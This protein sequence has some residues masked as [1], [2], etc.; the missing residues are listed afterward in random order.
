MANFP[1]L[2]LTDAGRQLQAK[3][4]IGAALT[5]SR[6]GLG[7]GGAD[8][9]ESMAALANE[10]LSLSI[11]DFEVV[12]DGTSRMRV[13][14]T[15]EHLESGFFVRE[16][17]VFARD[18]DT[19]EEVLY[20]YTNAGG[21]PDFLP[22][23][24]G[25][26]LVENVFDLYT[27]VGNA[28]NVT[29][30]INDYITIA[31]KQDVD[32]IR[33]LLLPT[34]GLVGQQPR[35][36]SNADGDVEWFDPAEGVDLRMSSVE[37]RRIAI[38]GQRTFGLTTTTTQ[39][40][41]IYVNGARMGRNRWQ[42]LGSTQMRFNTPL[43]DGDEV[44]FVQNEETGEVRDPRV[45]LTGDDLIYPGTENV[46]VVTDYDAF[47]SYEVTAS[48]GSV[49]RNG[50]AIMLTL[51]ADEPDGS[52]DLNIT[53][54]GTG[55]TYSLAVGAPIVRQ[56]ELISPGSGDTGVELTPT[57]ATASF[58]T[59][60]DAFDD[61]ASSDWQVATDEAFADIVWSA[62][63]STSLT[64]AQVPADAL[65]LNTQL[66]ARARH[67]GATLG[68]S[69]WSAV[70]AFTTTDQYIVRPEVVSP[71]NNATG[72]PES[73]IIEAS[74]FVTHPAG[75][76]THYATSWRLR[77]SG[78][79]VVWESL[80]DTANLNAVAIPAGVMQESTAYSVEAQYI[81]NSLPNSEWSATVTFT[82]SSSFIPENDAAGEPF[83]GGYFAQRMVDEVGAPYALVVAS[84]ADGEASGTMT[85]QDA[86]NY[87]EGLTIGGRN[88][89]RLPTVDECRALYWELKPTTYS[90]DTSYGA[91]S[92]IDP[93]TSNYTSG[94]PSQ[95]AIDAFK[96]GGAEAF[97]ASHYW[98]ATVSGSSAYRVHFTNGNE[99]LSSKT[100]SFYVRAVRREYF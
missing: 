51:A 20:S 8:A 37:E 53:R 100:F 73:P 95:T 23:G 99:L 2:V 89:W 93:P 97:I 29:A 45:S 75:V 1:G 7:D 19:G 70:V 10:L 28:Q 12:G 78:G 81:G 39:G 72:I 35:K 63:G 48:R 24:G 42:P 5:F 4:Q 55:I 65:P 31:T 36:A 88:D 69:G 84:K 57:L 22:A 18:P 58:S 96:D 3:A 76:D 21:Q 15:N 61:H 16:M 49:S 79:S 77:E 52:L 90:N 54:D 38:E 17:G 66:Y 98:S 46:Y 9:W 86:V 14:M 83:G 92:L 34:G 56:P 6:V 80:A 67:N 32:E 82:T 47:A 71:V 60:P 59:Y 43:V 30:V 44:L 13:I 94:N 62:M 68:A 25:A 64:A 40:L 74:A 85:W 26:T 41:G 87:C 33:P 50:E 11:Q 27:V 91:S